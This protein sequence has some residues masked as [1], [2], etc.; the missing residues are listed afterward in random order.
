MQALSKVLPSFDDETDDSPEISIKIGPEHFF[1]T[2]EHLEKDFSNFEDLFDESDPFQ[3]DG[4]FL[5]GWHALFDLVDPRVQKLPTFSTPEE[6]KEFIQVV[7]LSGSKRGMQALEQSSL[8]SIPHE[9]FDPWKLYQ[10]LCAQYPP[11]SSSDADAAITLLNRAFNN[12]DL[13]NSTANSLLKERGTS[14]RVLRLH[15]VDS[16][17]ASGFTS[18]FPNLTTLE[19]KE[20]LPWQTVRQL[21]SS[22]N[23]LQ[24]LTLRLFTREEIALQAFENCSELTN[25]HLKGVPTPRELKVVPY[26][27]TPIVNPKALAKLKTLEMKRVTLCK[28]TLSS[29]A[30]LPLELLDLCESTLLQPQELFKFKKCEKLRLLDLTDTTQNSSLD[31]IIIYLTKKLP[32]CMVVPEVTLSDYSGVLS[33]NSVYSGDFLFSPEDVPT[34]N[35]Q[36]L[37]KLLTETRAHS[38]GSSFIAS[39]PKNRRFNGNVLPWDHNLPLGLRYFFSA[40]PIFAP[41][42][43]MRLATQEPFDAITQGDFWQAVQDSNVSVIAM[44][45]EVDQ[46]SYLPEVGKTG[47]FVGQLKEVIN[48]HCLAKED[49]GSGIIL[50]RLKVDEKVVMHL[51]IDWK[52]MCGIDAPLL[53]TFLS[54]FQKLE[55]E[56]PGASLVHCKAGAGRTGTFFACLI[57][58]QLMKAAPKG[59]LHLDIKKLVTA[60]R[61]QRMSMILS[62]AQLMTVLEYFAICF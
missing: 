56:N 44:L 8:L 49:L 4:E 42:L 48:V 6:L 22:P 53:H 43:R 19:L 40:S 5:R 62:E 7:I 58:S 15:A 28:K 23:K 36:F 57:L 21:L 12:L 54:Y 50:R 17:M 25:L 34:T 38:R 9:S 61:D 32:R 10:E 59:D 45:K 41:D 47:Q 37:K 26:G 33:T 16:Q 11:N 29:L 2:R 24:V 46:T 35:P 30:A 39:L 14:Y 20:A 55:M 1:I 27:I 52:D 13:G 31:S 51:Q 18:F 3:L 60:L